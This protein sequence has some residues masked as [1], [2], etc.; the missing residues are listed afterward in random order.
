MTGVKIYVQK[1]LDLL[2]EV[3]DQCGYSFDCE[4]ENGER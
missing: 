1:D 4:A 3:K 2:Q